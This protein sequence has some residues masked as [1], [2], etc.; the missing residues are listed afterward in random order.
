M[1]RTISDL[2]TSTREK[3]ADSNV[4]KQ[5]HSIIS[6]FHSDQSDAPYLGVLW[7]GWD[8]QQREGLGQVGFDQH[9]DGN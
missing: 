2:K 9:E 7:G 1:S 3:F 5:R 6:P 8:L 4:L